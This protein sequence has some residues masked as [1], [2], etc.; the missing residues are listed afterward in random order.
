MVAASEPG[1]RI[2][3]CQHGVHFNAREIGH[4]TV[5]CAFCWDGHNTVHEVQIGRVANRHHTEEG[6][7]GAK[8]GVARADFVMTFAFEVIQ[9]CPASVGNGE[10]SR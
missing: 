10:S 8:A 7:N 4:E 6:A 5:V 1:G 2:W 9:K 3:S